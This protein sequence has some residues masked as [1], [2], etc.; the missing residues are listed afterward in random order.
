MYQAEG[1]ERKGVDGGLLL[2][3]FTYCAARSLA[4]PRSL[5]HA[6]CLRLFLPCL[7]DLGALR[8]HWRCCCV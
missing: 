3:A 4:L 7:I 6:R 2:L 8:R 5:L 1:E